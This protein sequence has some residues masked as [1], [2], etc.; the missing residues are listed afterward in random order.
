ME[1]PIT[2]T[3]STLVFCLANR[4][5]TFNNTLFL[6]IHN[7]KKGTWY[8]IKTTYYLL[9]IKTSAWTAALCGQSL[10]LCCGYIKLTGNLWVP[11]GPVGPPQSAPTHPHSQGHESIPLGGAWC[12]SWGCGR[13]AR[14]RQDPHAHF[15]PTH[16]PGARSPF[17]SETCSAQACTAEELPDPA[18]PSRG[19]LAPTTPWRFPAVITFRKIHPIGLR[20]VTLLCF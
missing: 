17:P 4:W 11:T 15:P 18:L 1:S 6:K 16:I 19:V 12:S 13:A 20:V 14:P 8:K 2:S 9:K 10:T 5:Y 3:P 7:L